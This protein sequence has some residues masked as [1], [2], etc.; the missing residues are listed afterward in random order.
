MEYRP[1]RN[2][3]RKAGIRSWFRLRTV[4][5]V[6]SAFASGPGAVTTTAWLKSR[7]AAK[8]GAQTSSRKGKTCFISYLCFIA[9]HS[10]NQMVMAFSVPV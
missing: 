9:R 8:A 10:R 5:A 3:A 7:T 1:D 4:A 2:A 6:L